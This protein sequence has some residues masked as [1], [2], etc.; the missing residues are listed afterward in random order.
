[1]VVKIV[2]PT[3]GGIERGSGGVT[4]TR[5]RE[6]AKDALTMTASRPGK[7]PKQITAYAEKMPDAKAKTKA[8]GTAVI[9]RPK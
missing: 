5:M 9:A 2:L 1:M 8:K 6:H 7:Q 4:A 3:E